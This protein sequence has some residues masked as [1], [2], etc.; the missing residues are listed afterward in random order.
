M[1][2]SVLTLLE[3]PSMNVLW[4]L[5]Y[6]PQSRQTRQDALGAIPSGTESQYMTP[7]S[8]TISQAKF[9]RNLWVSRPI[10]ALCSFSGHFPHHNGQRN[11]LMTPFIIK[12]SDTKNFR[13]ATCFRIKRLNL[14]GSSCFHVF[15]LQ[16]PPEPGP[17]GVTQT[18]HSGYL[19]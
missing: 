19:A 11:D 6:S 13:E 9:S 17:V 7:Q 14:S 12:H 16:H 3:L 18:A 2:N 4:I 10:A 8:L 15:L 5:H 1:S